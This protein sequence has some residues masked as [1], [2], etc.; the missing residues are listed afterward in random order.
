MTDRTDA[1][2]DPTDASAADAPATRAADCDVVVVGGGPAGCSAA[3][4]AARYDLDVR[5]FDCGRSSLRRCAH[6]GNYLGF[7]AGIDV[8]TFYALAHDHVET[9]GGSVVNDLV[10]VVERGDDAR[11]RVETQEGRTVRTRFVVAAAKY[12]GQYLRGLDDLAM[13]VRDEHGER[14]ER[15]DDAYPDADGSTPT[16][17]LYVAGPLAGSEDQAVI[18]AGHGARVGCAVVAAA[19]RARGWWDEVA[20]PT[21]WLRRR[22]SYDD[23]WDDRENWVEWFDEFHGDADVAPER[24]ERVRAA[25]VD[26]AMSAYVGDDEID[27]RT[28]RGQRR[29]IEQLNDDLICA[30]ADE[31]RAGRDAPSNTD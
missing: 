1:E 22:A 24:F 18:A 26:R 3:V 17:G 6:L 25:Y 13:F 20:D 8:E 14:D 30:R 23:K 5:V 10:E 15:F 27:R 28:E 16:E 7:P 21:D 9:A 12:D 19:R 29:L 4:F 11:F 31:I 2:G